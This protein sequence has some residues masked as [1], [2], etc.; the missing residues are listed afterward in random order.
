MDIFVD[1]EFG[2]DDVVC[3]QIVDPEEEYACFEE[4][5][6]NEVDIKNCI[7][8][9]N[10]LH[11]SLC[12]RALKNCEDLGDPEVKE[13]CLIEVGRSGEYQYCSEVSDK[14]QRR[15]C[16]DY[17][18]ERVNREHGRDKY[19]ECILYAARDLNDVKFCAESYDAEIKA[20]CID[21]FDT[22]KTKV[23]R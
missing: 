22:K 18:C 21:L 5:I 9:K 7:K 11:R 13:S 15:D 1:G 10:D 19:G 8:I 3:D 20:T 4:L 14:Y 23:V 12:Y 17:G 16:F 6:K 2:E